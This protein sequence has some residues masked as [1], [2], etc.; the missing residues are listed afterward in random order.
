[1]GLLT[2]SVRIFL[3]DDHEVVLQGLRQVLKSEPGFDVVGEASTAQ[4]GLD[5]IL[6]VVPDVAVIDVRLPDGNGVDVARDVRSA[7]PSVRCVMFTAFSAEDAFLRSVIAGAAGYLTK[8]ADRHTVLDTIR[9]V[10]AGESL[11]DPSTLD[12]IRKHNAATPD[13]KGLLGRLSPHEQRILRLVVDGQTNREIAVQMR[14]AEKTIRNYVSNIL[15]K[16]GLRNRTQL[17][18]YVAHLLDER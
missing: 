2:G 13:F 15:G 14:L 11:I 9:R 1:V 7:A 5:A 12:G 18:V 6:D 3:V 17:A 8:D 10:A 16:V 4:A